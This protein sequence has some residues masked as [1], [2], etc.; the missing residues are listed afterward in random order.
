VQVAIGKASEPD[1]IAGAAPQPLDA[2]VTISQ[3][4]P[5]KP[6]TLYRYDDHRSVPTTNYAKS[7]STLATT[8]VATAP[9]ATFPAVV[10]SNGVAVFR[11][12]PAGV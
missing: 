2:V 6:Y 8:F 5:G 12:L 9:Q 1:V 10:R 4:V 11:C 3:L 7:R